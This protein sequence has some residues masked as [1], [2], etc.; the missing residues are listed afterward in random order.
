HRM[1]ELHVAGVRREEWSEAVAQ[2]GVELDL[3]LAQQF[4]QHFPFERAPEHGSNANNTSSDGRQ[5]VDL[6]HRQ[7]VERLGQRVEIAR[8]N[9]PEQLA[10][11]ERV[12]RG[13]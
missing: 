7:R 13:S 10:N 8:T 4:E 5:R 1:T 6:A 11:E 2:R 9:Q 12:A 3:V